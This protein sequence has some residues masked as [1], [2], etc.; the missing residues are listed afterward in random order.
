M[1]S[2]RRVR[3]WFILMGLLNQAGHLY[4]TLTVNWKNLNS[5]IMLFGT[6]M[7]NPSSLE[8]IGA[9]K[10]SKPQLYAL[11]KNITI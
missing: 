11:C 2:T 1:T 8:Q 4:L 10:S 7:N 5:S 9:L 6:L 3:D